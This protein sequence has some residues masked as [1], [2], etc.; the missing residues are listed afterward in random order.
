[1]QKAYLSP[2]LNKAGKSKSLSVN[3][4]N[5]VTKEN[6]ATV[7]LHMFRSLFIGG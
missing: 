2:Q 7:L 4:Y 6:N 3:A 1:M 5:L